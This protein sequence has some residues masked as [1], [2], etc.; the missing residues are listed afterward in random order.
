MIVA[1]AQAIGLTLLA[2]IVVGLWTLLFGLRRHDESDTQLV[3][4]L[5]QDVVSD[6]PIL[7][8]SRLEMPALANEHES[9]GDDLRAGDV[10]TRRH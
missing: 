4:L 2:A 7:L 9:A 3:E 8:P 6:R 5:I 1:V 10:Q